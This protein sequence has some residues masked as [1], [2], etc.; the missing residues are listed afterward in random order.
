M[1]DHGECIK[2]KMFVSKQNGEL[3]MWRRQTEMLGVVKLGRL[4]SIKRTSCSFLF[5]IVYSTAEQNLSE[6]VTRANSNT[7]RHY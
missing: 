6:K 5:I 2:L 3:E 1:D 7:C 4:K